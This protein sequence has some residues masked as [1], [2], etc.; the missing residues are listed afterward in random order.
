MRQGFSLRRAILLPSLLASL[1]I[2]GELEAQ[3]PVGPSLVLPQRI[4]DF[5]TVI[6]G[7]K[8]EKSFL[9]RNVGTEPLVLSRLVTSCGCTV[10]TGNG[11]AIQ[12]GES[13]VV[14]VVI[15]TQGLS[16]RRESVI[17][18]F[19]NDPEAPLAEVT[20]RGAVRPL[21]DVSPEQVLFKN[22]YTY[23]GDPSD[24]SE[25][26]TITRQAVSTETWSSL[27]VV[28]LS[29][30]FS[31]EELQRDERLLKLRINLSEG[32]SPGGIRSRLVLISDS[33]KTKSQ[34]IPILATVKSPLMVE[35]RI[36]RLV[37]NEEKRFRRTVTVRNLGREPIEVTRVTSKSASVIS[38]VNEVRKGRE[39]NII[40]EVDGGDV[41]ESVRDTITLE[42]EP[43]LTA[44][45][46]LEVQ[47]I[48]PPSIS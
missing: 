35:P 47:V 46:V 9:V 2:F 10:V 25:E 8:V 11:V 20:V 28:P 33:D 45:P 36:L 29:P 23:G 34:N 12:P 5:G 4:I 6:A 48:A 16:N 41:K 17:R 15:D 22:I 13:Y 38:Q 37:V 24:F 18:I 14:P 39:Y 26:L 31:V 42:T 30:L 19:S 3:S 43:K 1:L 40:I 32:V 44:L 21:F 7:T 27:K